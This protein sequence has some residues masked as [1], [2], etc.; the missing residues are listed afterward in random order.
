MIEEVFWIL[1]GLCIYHLVGYPILI[2]I[3]SLF[4]KQKTRSKEITPKVS[5][6]IAAYNEEPVIEKK[7]KNS[8]KLDYP[9]LE[10]IVV[11]DGSTDNTNKICKKY[12]KIK[13]IEIK[14]RAGKINALNTA[15]PQAKGEILVFSDANVYY[16]EDCIKQLVKHFNDPKV[17]CVTGHVKLIAKQGKHKQG[18]GIYT[19]IERLIQIKESELSSVIG[20]DGAMYSLKKEL[21]Q[22]L[23]NYFIEDFIMG[24]NIIKQGYRV[25]YEKNAKAIEQSALSI[26][27][28]F[29]RKSRIVAGGFQSL[30]SL[31]FLIKYPLILFQFISH[32]LLR[33]LLSIFMILI[34]ILNI[35]LI[36]N[37]VYQITLYLQILLYLF[38]IIGS[39]IPIFSPFFYFTTM[40][41]ASFWGFFKYFFKLQKVTWTKVKRI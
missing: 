29:K 19:R 18:E 26:K 10:I 3:L 8:L 41:I 34:F 22:P 35:I 7:I 6:I 21:Y 39:I 11:S 13:L 30:K 37:P 16:K 33:W 24:M 17:G 25:I 40:Q 23:G 5:L 14:Q 38:T 27:D 32:K 36:S 20:L 12:K 1:I 15:V 28:E 31:F 9:N 4:F 2:S